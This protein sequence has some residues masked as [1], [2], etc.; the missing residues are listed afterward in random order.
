[1]IEDTQS[2]SCFIKTICLIFDMYIGTYINM[3]NRVL[4]FIIIK[5]KNKLI[6]M[7]FLSTRGKQSKNNENV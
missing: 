3:L 2:K 5:Y 1:M 7:I 4:S 6:T